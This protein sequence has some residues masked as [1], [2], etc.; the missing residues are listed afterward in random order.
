MVRHFIFGDTRQEM[1]DEK[2]MIQE[3]KRSTICVSDRNGGWKNVPIKK[4][5]KIFRH[6]H[7]KLV[8]FPWVLEVFV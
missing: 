3:D 4:V 2:K 8:S 6:S 5:G 7:T 1:R